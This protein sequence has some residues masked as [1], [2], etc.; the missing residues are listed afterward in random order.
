MPRRSISLRDQRIGPKVTYR[1]ARAEG[2]H[3]ALALGLGPASEADRFPDLGRRYGKL[4]LEQSC[5]RLRF[6]GSGPMQ[7]AVARPSASE[8]MSQ[9]A[10]GSEA[11][12]SAIPCTTHRTAMLF[13]K[14]LKCGPRRMPHNCI[15]CIDKVMAGRFDTSR[16]IDVGARPQ[17]RVKAT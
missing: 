16:K 12:R 14:L 17:R 8:H 2:S 11:A 13:Q 9:N 4:H 6:A 15:W 3:D 1:S 5:H 10:Q 7:I